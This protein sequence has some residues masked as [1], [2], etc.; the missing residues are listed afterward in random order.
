MHGC[1]ANGS[2]RCSCVGRGS[3]DARNVQIQACP[4]IVRGGRLSCT[5]PVP[6]RA[7]LRA[8][9]RRGGMGSRFSR[10]EGASRQSTILNGAVPCTSRRN[11]YSRAAAATHTAQRI[12][13][14]QTSC[15][16]AV[17]GRA[18]STAAGEAALTTLRFA[19]LMPAWAVAAVPHLEY[20]QRRHCDL[21][22]PLAHPA[23]SN[24]VPRH[25]FEVLSALNL[26]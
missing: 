1:S 2:C 19:Q 7:T 26:G 5:G 15:L 23:P 8:T 22:V 21:A 14:P 20:A 11:G 17:R 24:L 9:A 10:S 6:R 16:Y 4:K 18:G 3:R 25:G 13:R 12:C